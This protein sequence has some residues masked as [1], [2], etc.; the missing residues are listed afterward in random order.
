[1]RCFE[2]F[3]MILETGIIVLNFAGKKKSNILMTG[4][5]YIVALL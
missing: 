2:Q 1:M 4:L 3:H 5:G